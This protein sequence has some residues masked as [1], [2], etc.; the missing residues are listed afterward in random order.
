MIRPVLR[1]FFYT[2]ASLAAVS[3]LAGGGIA[4]SRGIET[5][6]MAAVVLSLVRHFIKPF[7]NILLLPINLMTLGLFHWVASAGLLYLVT[8]IVPG[9]SIAEFNFLGFYSQPIVVPAIHLTGVIAFIAVS[10]LI[11][12]INSFLYWLAGR[13]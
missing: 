2:A 10:F 6:F 7:L 3:Y 13:H 11:S 1:S 5:F 9:F 4:F 8:L 12:F